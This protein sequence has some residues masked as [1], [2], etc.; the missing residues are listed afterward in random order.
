MAGATRVRVETGAETWADAAV[1]IT[2][3]VLSY[4]QQQKDNVMAERRIELQELSLSIE[5][6]KAATDRFRSNTE[7]FT[8]QISARRQRSDSLK[9]KADIAY[10][11]RMASVSE[12]GATT[13]EALA[14]TEATKTDYMGR[15]MDLDEKVN[16]QN[17]VDKANEMWKLAG[18]EA[19]LAIPAAR[20][21][22]DNAYIQFHTSGHE[23]W[24][25][26]VDTKQAEEDAVFEHDEQGNLIFNPERRDMLQFRSGTMIARVWDN[27]PKEVKSQFN[28]SQGQYLEYITQQTMTEYAKL[29]YPEMGPQLPPV[30]K[31]P[32]SERHIITIGYDEVRGGTPSSGTIDMLYRG[33]L[34]REVASDDEGLIK[35]LADNNVSNYYPGFR[36]Y[37][38]NF[39]S[40]VTSEKGSQTAVVHQSLLDQAGYD[41]KYQMMKTGDVDRL[42]IMNQIAK[43]QS[44]ATVETKKAGWDHARNLLLTKERGV[45]KYYARKAKEQKDKDEKE[46]DK[47]AGKAESKESNRLKS[48][49]RAA[50]GAI[51]DIKTKFGAD[52]SRERMIKIHDQYGSKSRMNPDKLEMKQAYNNYLRAQK[53]DSTSAPK[54]KPKGRTYNEEE[55]YNLWLDTPQNA[56]A[57]AYWEGGPTEGEALKIRGDSGTWVIAGE[58]GA[59]VRSAI[60]AAGNIMVINA[61]T[62]EI[63]SVT[64]NDIIRQKK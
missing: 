34:L 24:Y 19:A 51:K 58:P 60:G 25:E 55:Q 28:D 5:G 44:D 35:K 46:A 26:M 29:K 54:A 4:A 39:D 47:K 11:M 56:N 62:G 49:D 22:A 37:L 59:Q 36:K 27:L 12:R 1:G 41:S 21:A 2:G 6:D 18:E 64:R 32:F 38:K 15:R 3:L 57:K 61:K 20:Q 30:Y 13:Q 50:D 43:T 17:E 23:L 53:K 33:V 40:S 42:G 31:S 10:G 52:I 45:A 16:R 63:K 48:L 14:G 9:A 7:R 8:Q